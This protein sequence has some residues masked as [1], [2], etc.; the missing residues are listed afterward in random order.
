M[1][2]QITLTHNVGTTPIQTD[3]FSCE[4]NEGWSRIF[5][6]SDFGIAAN[7]QFSIKS[8]QIALSKSHEG[9]SLQFHVYSIDE[10]FPV[11]FHSLYPRTLLGVRGVGQTPVINGA[12]EIIQ[13]DFDE[14]IIVPA[15]TDRILVTVHKIEDFYNPASAQVF[16][17]GTEQDTG[18]SWYE[19]CQENYSL[20]PTTDLTNPVPNANFYINVTG[21]VYDVKS[22]GNTTRLSHNVCDDIIETGIHSCSSSYVYWARAFN[23]DDFN[24]STNEEFVINSGQVGINKTGWLPEISFNIYKIDDNFPAS[25]SESDLIGSS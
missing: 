24:I 22:L 23:L 25:F 20:T 16:I 3:M 17:A 18:A 11:F 4:R 6:L 15:G 2:G 10:D 21:D 7:E 5:K 9:A 13:T 1:F 12:P 14:P 8:G 19:G